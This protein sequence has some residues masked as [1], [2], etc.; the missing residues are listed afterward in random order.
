MELKQSTGRTNPPAARASSS[1][2]NMMNQSTPAVISSPQ[3]TDTSAPMDIGQ[4]KPHTETRTCYNCNKPGHILPNCLEPR[5]Q[6]V[7]RAIMEVDIQDLVAKAVS[8]ALDAWDK[9][10]AETKEEV[11]GDF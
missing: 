2:A 6:R 5:K 10:K 11:K 9:A 3:T 7:C 1:V 4:C 8:A